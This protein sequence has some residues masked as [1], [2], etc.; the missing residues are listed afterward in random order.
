M[1]RPSE[2]TFRILEALLSWPEDLTL[3]GENLPIIAHF[4][5]VLSPL[6]PFSQCDISLL[7]RNR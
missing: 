4:P 2:Q 5:L 6:G 7:E 3:Q 1:A